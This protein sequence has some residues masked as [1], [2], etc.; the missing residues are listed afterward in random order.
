M[1]GLQTFFSSGSLINALLNMGAPALIDIRV[2]GTDLTADYD[3]AVSRSTVLSE[4]WPSEKT[5]APCESWMCI[6][7]DVARRSSVTRLN[8]ACAS[9]IRRG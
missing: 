5:V 7:G 3:Y 1:P 6:S 2:P 8:H 4:F 9:A